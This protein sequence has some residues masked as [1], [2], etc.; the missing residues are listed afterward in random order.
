MFATG[1]DPNARKAPVSTS[2]LGTGRA[3]PQTKGQAQ[4]GPEGQL[5][6]LDDTLD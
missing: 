2:D 6:W 1:L 5:I 4:R 3:D